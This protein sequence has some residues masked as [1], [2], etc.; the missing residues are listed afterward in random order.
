METALAQLGATFLR[1]AIK[2]RRAQQDKDLVTLLRNFTQDQSAPTSVGISDAVTD[3]RANASDIPQLPVVPRTSDGDSGLNYVL[4]PDTQSYVVPRAPLNRGDFTLTENDF[5]RNDQITLPRDQY[6][7][8]RQIHAEDN[9]HTSVLDRIVA[10]AKRLN[11]LKEEEIG[12]MPLEMTYFYLFSNYQEYRF[13]KS[14]PSFTK[15]IKGPCNVVLHELFAEEWEHFSER[16]KLRHRHK[17]QNQ[18]YIGRRW[19]IAVDHLSSGV[20]LLAGKKIST[21]M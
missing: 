2:N 10:A 21:L 9:A 5:I 7:H 11:M 20:I 16:T 19:S 13:G 1:H 17:L 12:S 14:V 3:D 15:K 6:L 8:W 18:L 4:K